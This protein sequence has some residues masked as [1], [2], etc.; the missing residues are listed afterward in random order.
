MSTSYCHVLTRAT[1]PTITG[2]RLT[3]HLRSRPTSVVGTPVPVTPLRVSWVSPMAGT[4]LGLAPV[5]AV[6]NTGE[7]VVTTLFVKPDVG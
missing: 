3:M 5:G 2:V 1:W 4:K 6:K 7:P